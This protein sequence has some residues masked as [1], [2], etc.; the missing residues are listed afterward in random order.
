MIRAAARCKLKWYSEFN[1]S[2]RYLKLNGYHFLSN[3]QASTSNGRRCFSSINPKVIEKPS[4]DTPLANTKNSKTVTAGDI[5]LESNHSKHHKPSPFSIQEQDIP[6]F[7]EYKAH[8]ATQTTSNFALRPYQQE[9]ISDIVSA[10]EQGCSRVGVSMATGGGKTVIF[11][12]LVSAVTPRDNQGEKVL[13][14]VHRRELAAQAQEK[15]SSVNPHLKVEI[16][17]GAQRAS[18][19]ADVIIASV[20]TLASSKS[21]RLAEPRFDPSLFKLIIID[22]AH[23]SAAKTY[24][25]ILKHFSATS[26]DT[27]VYVTGFSATLQRHDQISLEIAMDKV[28]YDRD[29]FSMIEDGHLCDFSSTTIKATINMKSVIENEE[30]E[31]KRKEQLQQEKRDYLR[32]IEESVSEDEKFGLY[33]DLERVSKSLKKL[34]V[35]KDF[36]THNLSQVLNTDSVN[37]L[38]F[39]VWKK[40]FD[41][42]DIKST[43]VFCVDIKHCKDLC[44]LFRKFGVNAD[45]VTGDTKDVNRAEAVN[46]FKSGEI[47]VLLNCGIFTEGTDIPNIDSIFMLRPTRSV[48]LFMQMLGR[49][50]RLYPGK[51]ICR[52]FDF[53]GNLSAHKSGMIT[54]PEIMG[55][56]PD[57]V[58]E[59]TSLKHMRANPTMFMLPPRTPVDPE[60]NEKPAKASAAEMKEKKEFEEA[61]EIVEDFRSKGLLN[62][63]L[64]DVEFTSFEG[65]INLLGAGK[66][67]MYER[68]QL[69]FSHSPYDWIRVKNNE[70]ILSGVNKF[71]RVS[72]DPDAEGTKWKIEPMLT[73][74]ALKFNVKKKATVNI[75]TENIVSLAD[76]ISRK[77]FV[78]EVSAKVTQKDGAWRNKKPSENQIARVHKVLK[79]VF[80][81]KKIKGYYETYKKLNLEFG[82]L[83]IE[84]TFASEKSK[85]AGKKSC[86]KK[87]Q[88]IVDKT[89]EEHA[90]TDM[91]SQILADPFEDKLNWVNKLSRGQIATLLTMEKH[92]GLA[93]ELERFLRQVVKMKKVY[94]KT[95]ERQQKRREK[96]EK[97]KEKKGTKE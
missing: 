55:L 97:K 73:Y 79:K 80:N 62:P 82:Q 90:K 12:H 77:F 61:H 70:Y 17:M 60:E 74:S 94:I 37:E 21:Q 33:S 13:V 43:I 54:T 59:N 6:L 28:V 19:D 92:G 78:E 91:L 68:D 93:H 41:L 22:E 67:T 72:P 83:D 36:N 71:I 24:V 69:D 20:S 14:L 4:I 64:G 53:V 84:Q 58:L 75:E 88:D 9:C 2:N 7:Q 27:K 18:D 23:H 39:G 81:L 86:S 63:T 31:K 11:S 96:E 1:V 46:K 95:Q 65:I 10:F 15:I 85:N 16:E 57:T 48:G 34:T 87:K 40:Y 8:E 5:N 45:Y 56:D 30:F 32:L 25:K 89:E 42:Q 47:P 35:T 76:E 26:S 51:T 44:K 29:V 38:A 50:L 49:G 3:T 66:H 52:V